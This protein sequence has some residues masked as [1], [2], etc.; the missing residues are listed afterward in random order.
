MS[1]SI[2]EKLVSTQSAVDFGFHTKRFSKPSILCKICGNNAQSIVFYGTISSVILD[3]DIDFGGAS[4]KRILEQAA[5]NAVQR[6][7][8]RRG[9]DFAN[10][11]LWERP[12][13]H[14][15]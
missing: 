15:T 3:V 10:D 9:S 11:I 13:G 6:C 1:L 5:D 2:T 14:G 7:D 12:D 8:G 4:V